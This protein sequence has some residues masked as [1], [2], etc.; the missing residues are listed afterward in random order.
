MYFQYAGSQDPE[1]DYALLGLARSQYE[2]DDYIASDRSYKTLKARNPAL[3]AK[4][5]YLGSVYGGE[6]RAWS[7]ADR[8]ATT[9]WSRSSSASV[10]MSERYPGVT[11]RLPGESDPIPASAV[12]VTLAP[13]SPR[14]FAAYPLLPS[15]VPLPEVA[16]AIPEVSPA[17]ASNAV[18]AAP[19]EAPTGTASETPPTV[20]AAPASS[21]PE[22]PAVQTSSEWRVIG[23][24]F[25]ATERGPGT[26]KTEGDVVRQID[27]DE[28]FAKL[29]GP[30]PADQIVRYSFS[31]RSLG[32]GWVGLGLHV[33]VGGVKTHTGW[34][35]GDSWLVWLTR[36][37]VHF[38]KDQTRVQIYHS[39]SDT[40]MTLVVD[41]PVTGS[42]RDWNR[43]AVVTDRQTHALTVSLNDNEVISLPLPETVQ[44]P[45]RLALRSID[46]AEFQDFLIEAKP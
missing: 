20:A 40:Q 17:S 1:D 38:A 2:L 35:E 39:T 29:I 24:G 3:A 45:G 32:R 15:P 36:D 43:F 8:F 27:P 23:R 14:G 28:F 11:D 10:A 41:K 26:W 4:F 7:L 13:V 33:L 37:P 16:A 19:V 22:A 18:A 44:G 5:G 46:K 21:A 12:Y 25:S 34:G 9:N 6:G 31:A 42:I 30:S